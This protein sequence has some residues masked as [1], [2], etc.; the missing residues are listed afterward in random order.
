VL[1]AVAAAPAHAQGVVQGVIMFGSASAREDVLVPLAFTG[2]QL[3]LG[4]RYGFATGPH[5][6]E[7]ELTAGIGVLYTRFEQQAEQLS[8]GLMLGYARTLDEASGRGLALGGV[9]RWRDEL[10]YLESWDDAHGYW[11]STLTLGPL[12]LHELQPLS[13][14]AVEGRGERTGASARAAFWWSRT[15]SSCS[16]PTWSIRRTGTAPATSSR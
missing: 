7:S 2:P 15:A 1:V 4:A 8:H 6:L 13:W 9:L 11:L 5:R 12:V 16:K 10:S 14:L 3:E